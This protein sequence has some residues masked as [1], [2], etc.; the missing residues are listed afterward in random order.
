ME[1]RYA[2][3]KARWLAGERDRELG[4]RLMCFAWMHWTDP[5][6]VTGL[7][8]DPMAADLW[9]EMFAHFGGENSTDAKFLYVSGDGRTLPLGSRRRNGMGATRI[10]DAS[11][12]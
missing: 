1:E 6:F 3:L 7:A 2:E 9:H 8:D 12:R 10:A 11:P 4:L 5:P